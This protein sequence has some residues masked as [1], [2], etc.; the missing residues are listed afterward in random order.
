MGILEQADMIYLSLTKKKC[1][2]NYFPPQNFTPG[3]EQNAFV[4]GNKMYKTMHL[5]I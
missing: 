1:S 3:S 5:N 4:F 2:N